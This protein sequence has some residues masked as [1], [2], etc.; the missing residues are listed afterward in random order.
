[1]S[2]RISKL[3]CS[4]ASHKE[5]LDWFDTAITESTKEANFNTK[6][7]TKNTMQTVENIKAELLKRLERAGE[8]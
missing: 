5:L 8:Q 4:T 3:K 2:M 1:M 6:G 7:T